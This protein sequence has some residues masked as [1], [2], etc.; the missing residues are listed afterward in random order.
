[1]EPTLAKRVPLTALSDVEAFIDVVRELKS[2]T[3]ILEQRKAQ[4]SGYQRALAR[5]IAGKTLLCQTIAEGS[6]RVA[7]LWRVVQEE[8]RIIAATSGAADT[9]R[10]S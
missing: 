7:T 4:E 3:V 6:P 9:P 2:L 5:Q 1:M 10:P 8:L